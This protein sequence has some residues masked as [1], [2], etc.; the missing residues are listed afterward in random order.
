MAVRFESS[1]KFQKEILKF[2]R[3]IS[4]SENFVQSLIFNWRAEGPNSSPIWLR[5]GSLIC[6]CQFFLVK[7]LF[8]EF[9]QNKEL[10]WIKLAYLGIF[11]KNYFIILLIPTLLNPIFSPCHKFKRKSFFWSI[12]NSSNLLLRKARPNFRM[13][14]K[15]PRNRSWHI[16]ELWPGAYSGRGF[17]G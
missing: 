9:L 15:T 1:Q 6:Q 16:N 12:K 11:L 3:K 14:Y 7:I 5:S 17:G 2:S 8:L 13:T 10:L 4:W